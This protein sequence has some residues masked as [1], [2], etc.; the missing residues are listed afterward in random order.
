VRKRGEIG[1]GYQKGESLGAELRKTPCV[2]VHG[3]PYMEGLWVRQQPHPPNST[4]HA[5][6][7]MA[8][9]CS[10]TEEGLV[11]ASRCN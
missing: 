8:T 10:E 1:E 6:S 2:P 7:R 11:E 9:L 3:S 4:R 5:D